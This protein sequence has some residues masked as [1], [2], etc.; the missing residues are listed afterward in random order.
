LLAKEFER[1]HGGT[2]L[3]ASAW[4]ELHQ[5]LDAAITKAN[6]GV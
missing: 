2:H 3:P 4:M 5:K 6:E 1:H